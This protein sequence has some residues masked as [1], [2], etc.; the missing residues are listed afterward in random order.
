MEDAYNNQP[1]LAATA[2][3]GQVLKKMDISAAGG[4]VFEKFAEFVKNDKN[5]GIVA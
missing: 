3:F 4:F 2:V 5:A 1:A